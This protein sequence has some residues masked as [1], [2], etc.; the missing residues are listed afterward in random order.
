MSH[1]SLNHS[2]RIFRCCAT[3]L[4]FETIKSG[5][6]IGKERRVLRIDLV[7]IHG[8]DGDM[9][10]FP[11]DL[12]SMATLPCGFANC[13]SNIIAYVALDVSSGSFVTGWGQQH[14]RYSLKAR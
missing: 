9:V 10:V 5:M 1:V 12:P 3:E 4:G 8:H 11:F 6:K 13:W 7:S 2:L 14:V